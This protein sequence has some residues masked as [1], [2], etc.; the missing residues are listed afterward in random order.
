MRNL[1]YKEFRLAISALFF[2]MPLFGVLLLI[3]Q[4]PYFIAMMYFFFIAVPN[5]FAVAKAQGDIGFSASLPVRR[6]DIVKSRMMSV[7]LLE[8]LQIVVA[9]LFAV[10]N[11]LLY[12][13]GNFLLDTNAAFFGFT[14]V[15]YGLYN[16]ILFPMFYKTAYKIALPTI[17]AIV[18]TV[19]FAGIVETAVQLVPFAKALDGTQNI[20]AQMIVLFGGIVVYIMLTLLA[21]KLS[22]KRFERVNI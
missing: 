8:L 13:Q 14:F 2:T 10:G 5:I 21:S 19:V 20:P 6:S 22:V 9:A 16:A 4:W 3:P 12:P 18:A 15:M 11:L 17:T 1:L 7:A